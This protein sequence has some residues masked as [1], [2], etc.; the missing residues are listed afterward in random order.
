MTPIHIVPSSEV[1]T[2]ISCEE[3]ARLVKEYNEACGLF[4]STPKGQQ[5][6]TFPLPLQGASSQMLRWLY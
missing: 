2:D 5:A 4:R 1:P 3:K 6:L